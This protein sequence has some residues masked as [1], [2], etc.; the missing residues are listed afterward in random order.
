[1]LDW[2]LSLFGSGKPDFAGIDPDD[3]ET[4]WRAQHEISMVEGEGRQAEVYPK[5]GIKSDAQWERVQGAFHQ[6]HS[7][8]PDF[9][10]AASRVGMQVQMANFNRAMSGGA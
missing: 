9:R 10:A 1:M 4:Y 5:Y 6:R 3:Y 2:I 8:N 7:D